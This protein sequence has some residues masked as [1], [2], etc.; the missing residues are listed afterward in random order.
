MGKTRQQFADWDKG[1]TRI[2]RPVETANRRGKSTASRT[3][4]PFTPAYTFHKGDEIDPPATESSSAPPD[5]LWRAA[6][7]YDNWLWERKKDGMPEF[8]QA[9]ETLCKQ[10]VCFWIGFGGSIYCESREDAMALQAYFSDAVDVA[11]VAI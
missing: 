1:C 5:R 11:D 3:E 4:P 6:W 8:G 7:D 2:V 10:R 9:V